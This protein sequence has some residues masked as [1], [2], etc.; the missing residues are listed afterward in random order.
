LQGLTGTVKRLS[1][2][3]FDYG[4]FFDGQNDLE[5]LITKTQK[6]TD[7]ANHQA[8][9]LSFFVDVAYI[10]SL[11]R[12]GFV[13]EYKQVINQLS[14]L[15]TCGHELQ[16]QWHPH[17]VTST[18]NSELNC[19]NFI[20]ADYSWN[21]FVSNNGLN[22]MTDSLRRCLNIFKTEFNITPSAFRMGGLAVQ[23]PQAYL[24]TIEE[25][26]FTIECS[27]LPGLYKECK[28]FTTD[29]RITPPKSHWKIDSYSGCFKEQ[30]KGKLTEIPIS[31]AYFNGVDLW[32]KINLSLSYRWLK[33]SSQQDENSQEQSTI[34]LELS[35]E[36]IPKTATLDKADRA[37]KMLFR[38]LTEQI[39]ESGSEF[40]VWTN[41]PKNLNLYSWSALRDYIEWVKN[42]NGQ[43]I[44]IE[45][46][47]NK[48]Y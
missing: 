14:W 18:W 20:K 24:E 39:W 2:L 27:V 44:T 33:W 6:L 38:S 5:H 9:P 1:V 17:W 16:L 34:N 19:W 12:F 21:G 43:L 37:T 45:S 13:Q 4:I 28:Y 22:K 7:I 40:V 47:K 41:H 46:L 42:N 25:L 10:D 3:T 11:K 48:L 29:H 32:R 31:Q 8:I 26:G 30:Q 36:I 15:H 35:K 23:E